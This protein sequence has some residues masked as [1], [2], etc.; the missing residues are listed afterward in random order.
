MA[1]LANI[2]YGFLPG[3]AN[4]RLVFLI[5]RRR[6]WRRKVLGASQKVGLF[7]LGPNASR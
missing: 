1:D 4:A 2:L 5:A 3:S 7:E 6:G